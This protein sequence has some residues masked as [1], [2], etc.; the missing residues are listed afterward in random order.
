MAIIRPTFPKLST[1]EVFERAAQARASQELW[2]RYTLSERIQRLRDLWGEVLKAKTKLLHIVHEETGKPPQEIE[3]TEIAAVELTLKHFTRFA[4]RILGDA[5]VPKPWFYLNKRAYVHHVPR[6]VVGIIT[7]WA[8]PIQIPYGDTF[9]ALLAGNAV[10]LKPSEWTPRTALFLSDLAH[11]SGLLP[12]G[13]LH[14]ILGGAETGA[15]VVEAC[16]MIAFTGSSEAG[17]RVAKAAAERLKPAVLELSGKHAMVVLK[18]APL[19]RA[20]KA[21]VWGAFAQSGHTCVSVEQVFVH[22]QVYQ[23]FCELAAAELSSIRQSAEFGVEADMGRIGTPQRYAVVLDAISDAREKG[24]RI[25]G[26]EIKDADHLLVSPALILDA[27][28]S[29]KA[30]RDEIFGPVLAIMKVRSTEE[31]VSRANE[32][33]YGLSASV[34]S[35]DVARAEALARFMSFGLVSVNELSVHP[36]VC[37]LPFG[38]AKESGSGRRNSDEGLRMY[39]QPQSVVIHEWPPDF[40]EINWFPYSKTKARALSWLSRLA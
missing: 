37:G 39:C 28:M 19:N 34:W 1:D 29:M 35:R 26:G 24:A 6:G 30:M 4:H 18:D 9:A 38:G 25:I 13:L 3:S 7:P 11:S 22:E 40:A 15:A 8:L 14:V 16:D 21:A 31:A 36:L 33:A 12:D 10:L 32:N 5:A 27:N 2:R 23:E 17:R 20:V